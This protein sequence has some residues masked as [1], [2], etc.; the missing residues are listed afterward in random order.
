MKIGRLSL[1]LGLVALFAPAA[2]AADKAS[3]QIFDPVTVNGQ[4]L[5]AGNYT[6]TWQG[7]AQNVDVTFAQGKKVVVKAP[8]KLLDLP[9]STARDA[10][11][12]RR[13]ADGTQSLSQIQFAGKKYAL[14][15][16]E[17]VNQAEASGAMK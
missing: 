5:A 14:E 4:R 11:V 7:S 15:L 8:A 3:V 12:T 2:F 1:L 13:N 9:S 16:G 17:P 10:V 6:V